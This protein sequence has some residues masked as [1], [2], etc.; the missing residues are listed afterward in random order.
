MSF[1]RC[2]LGI[3]C[4]RIQCRDPRGGRYKRDTE[5]EMP[6]LGREKIHQ[7]DGT[8]GQRRKEDTASPGFLACNRQRHQL[9]R[10]DVIKR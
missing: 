4:V 2:V 5:E 1:D 3:Y 8:G 6:E 10:E 9:F 7:L